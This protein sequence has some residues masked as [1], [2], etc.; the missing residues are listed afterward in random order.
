MSAYTQEA[1]DHYEADRE[2]ARPNAGAVL[3]KAIAPYASHLGNCRLESW[4]AIGRK[5]QRCDCGLFA[6]LERIDALS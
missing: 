3:A 5:T 4:I 1:A 2:E 6:L